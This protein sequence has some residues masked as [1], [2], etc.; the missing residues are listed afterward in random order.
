MTDILKN[1]KGETE[2]QFLKNYDSNKYQKPS[3]TVDLL[4][5]SLIDKPKTD[6]RASTDKELK[7]LLIKRKDHPY[8]G[9]WAL[10]GGFVNIDESITTAAYRE[11]K[12]ETGVSDVYL[13]QLYTFGDNPTRDPRMRVISVSYIALTSN[14]LETVSGDDAS[15]AKWFTVKRNP[16]TNDI[17]SFESD[18]GDSFSYKKENSDY[19]LISSN[20]ENSK[21]AFDHIQIINMGLE[22]LKNKIEYT[23]IVFELMPKKF[24]LFELQKAYEIILNKKLDKSNFRKTIIDKLE[25]TDET[26]YSGIKKATLY[27]KRG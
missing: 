4:V 17:I 21:L 24:T 23:N 9:Q 27:R 5:F 26:S 6:L 13:E 12:E 1:D 15:D 2:S 3:V 25:K 18:D 14:V 10:P 22:R 11:L 16:I 19:Q 7:L 8:I 20:K